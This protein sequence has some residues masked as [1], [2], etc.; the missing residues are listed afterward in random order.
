MEVVAPE[1]SRWEVGLVTRIRQIVRDSTE[2]LWR[3]YGIW[4]A[5]VGTGRRVKG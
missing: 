1:R 4:S 2:A 3:V 5:T